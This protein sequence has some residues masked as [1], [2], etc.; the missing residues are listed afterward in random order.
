MKKFCELTSRNDLADFLLIK[1]AR[2]TNIL[3]IKKVDSYYAMFKIPKRNGGEREINAPTG[4]LKY[5]QKRILKKIIEFQKS[6][7]K[8]NDIKT[9]ISHGFEIGKSIITNAKIHKNKRYVLNIDLEDFFHSFHF[10]RVR[11]F[12]LKNKYF[13][14]P[15]EVATVL[16]QLTCY[17]GVLPQGAPTSPIITNLICRVLDIRLLNIA[18]KYKLDYTRY[19]DDLTFST[20]CKNFVEGYDDFIKKIKKEI[21][22]SGFKINDK[23]TRLLYK[24]TRQIVTGLVVNKKLNV[25]Q[26]YYRETRAMAQSLY[27]KGGFLINGNPGKV[28]QL[29]GRFSFINQVHWYNNKRDGLEHRL[30]TLTGREKEIKKFLFYKYFYHNTAPLIITEGKTDVRY[31]KAALKS[32]YHNYPELIEK[33]KKGD[34]DFKIKFFN[35]TKRINYF[36][37][38]YTDGADALQNIYKYFL[39]KASDRDRILYPNYFNYFSKNGIYP[40]YPIIILLDNE[41][42]SKRPLYKFMHEFANARIDELKNNLWIKMQD[43]ANIY[44]MTNKLVNNMEEC[45]IEHLF[46]KDVLD[47]KIGGKSFSLKGEDSSTHYSKEIFSQYIAH[48]YKKIDFTNFQQ[49]LDTITSIIKSYTPYINP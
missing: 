23:K 20:N 17:K 9:N 48:N 46:P 35:R 13:H 24:N 16:A 38:V 12:F 27:F 22:R 10:G 47:H 26:N 8:E 14:L 4:D 44:I 42:K 49:I 18:K 37:G 41:L 25:S 33:N 5:V 31:L 19:A 36:L 43:K 6:I 21:E 32:L 39:D 3:Y 7:I 40:L 2:L 45:E 15:L 28:E 30:G 34:F 1:R 11:G 29:E